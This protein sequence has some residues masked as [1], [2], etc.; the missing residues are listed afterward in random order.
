[1]FYL[2]FLKKSIKANS[3]LALGAKLTS[4][5][6]YDKTTSIIFRFLYFPVLVLVLVCFGLFCFFC[7]IIN[8]GISF[9]SFFVF[10]VFSQADHSVFVDVGCTK[11]MRVMKK[12][13]KFEYTYLMSVQISQEMKC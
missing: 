10:I 7:G 1:M 13:L 6:P 3:A 5:F 2:R 9:M 4:R 8:P 11:S 12:A